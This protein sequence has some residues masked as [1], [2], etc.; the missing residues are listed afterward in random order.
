MKEMVIITAL[1]MVC[2]A[3]FST[4]TFKDGG[5]HPID[6]RINDA[7]EVDPGTPGVG[8]HVELTDG[9]WIHHGSSIGLF[10]DSKLTVSGGKTDWS[11]WALD[12]SVF[13]MSGGDLGGGLNTYSSIPASITG[14][15][16]NSV[17]AS[18][19]Y[20]GNTHVDFKNGTI[21]ESFELE[22]GATGTISGGKIS[23]LRI[24]FPCVKLFQDSSLTISGGDFLGMF[25]AGWYATDQ[26]LITLDGKDFS[27]N[28]V[29]VENGDYARSYSLNGR[30]TG[31]L[32]NGDSFNNLYD[33][34]GNSD[35]LFVPES[36]TLMLVGLGGLILRKRNHR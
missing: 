34:R 21:R 19:Y 28:G 7:V 24:E 4:V 16:M 8:T 11:V 13:N 15:S 26:T 10:N 14:G 18:A 12:N 6:Y 9:G 29:P 22:K 2:S 3:A 25:Q 33:I 20:S 27:I 30:I 17:S 1:S 35:I 5:Y 23:V 36:A 32:A 31:T